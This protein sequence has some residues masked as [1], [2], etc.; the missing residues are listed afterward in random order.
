[1]EIPLDKWTGF[2]VNENGERIPAGRQT[3][4]VGVS[5]PDEKSVALCGVK[6][7]VIEP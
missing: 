2:V 1:M 5:Q 6:P 3:F 7:A 4:F